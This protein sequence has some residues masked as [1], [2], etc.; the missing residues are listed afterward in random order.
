M[1]SQLR[2]VK[3]LAYAARK[4]HGRAATRHGKRGDPLAAEVL[5]GA[6]VVRLVERDAV[7]E[8]V[9]D[10]LG[11]CGL[12]PWWRVVAGEQVHCWVWGPTRSL[13][14]RARP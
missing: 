10:A 13:S 7:V 3:P 9:A 12:R 1:H 5:D 2:L 6:R 14:A 8:R 4:I 11:C